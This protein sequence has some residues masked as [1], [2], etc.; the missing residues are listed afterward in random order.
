MDQSARRLPNS[1]ISAAGYEC[2]AIR[3]TLVEE[4]NALNLGV[5]EWN[6]LLTVAARGLNLGY[7]PDGDMLA[8]GA[9]VLC[10]VVDALK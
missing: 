4:A 2:R 10:C 8:S 6:R 5:E 1:I 7:H 9:A 3:P